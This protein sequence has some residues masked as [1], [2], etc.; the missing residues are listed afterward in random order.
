MTPS[1]AQFPELKREKIVSSRHLSYEKRRLVKRRMLLRTGSTLLDRET[2][3]MRSCSPRKTRGSLLVS[4]LQ[5][6]CDRSPSR[7]W[8]S[9]GDA[10][11][12]R[13][14]IDMLHLPFV[15]C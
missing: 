12:S 9:P 14:Y 8:R 15:C 11:H 7:L 4:R 2:S 6:V 5:A 1:A 3:E 13:L 10:I